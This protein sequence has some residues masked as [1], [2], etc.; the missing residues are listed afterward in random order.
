[1]RSAE[2]ANC[3]HRDAENILLWVV[4]LRCGCG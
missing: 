2:N 4:V 1:L 3:H